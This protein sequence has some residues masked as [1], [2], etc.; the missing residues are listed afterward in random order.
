MTG[1]FLDTLFHHVPTVAGIAQ[2]RRENASQGRRLSQLA[3]TVAIE[4]SGL[5]LLPHRRQQMRR[6]NLAGIEGVEA[7]DADGQGDHRAQ[8]DQH[9]QPAA[10][11]YQFQHVAIP[12][13]QPKT[14]Y[15]PRPGPDNSAQR[16]HQKR[17]ASWRWTTT[18]G[19]A[20]GSITH[21]TAPCAAVL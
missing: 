11:G 20:A 4:L 10:R 3:Q 13:R 2:A 21:S 9:H 12:S 17:R 6:S 19:R 18:R 16:P 14:H 15:T 7:L 1:G 8:Q 5:E